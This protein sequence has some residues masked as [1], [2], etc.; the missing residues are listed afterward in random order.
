MAG[1]KTL[2]QLLTLSQLS[3]SA[4]FSAISHITCRFVRQI[5]PKLQAFIIF[6]FLTGPFSVLILR[7]YADYIFA[8]HETNGTGNTNIQKVGV[9]R[10]QGIKPSNFGHMISRGQEAFPLSLKQSRL[11]KMIALMLDKE[12]WTVSPGLNGSRS[13]H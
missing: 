5:L 12:C 9:N 13:V 3:K 10:G 6:F 4:N 1:R 11:V 7:L 8:L 2:S